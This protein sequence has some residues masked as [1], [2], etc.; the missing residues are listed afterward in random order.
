MADFLRANRCHVL[1]LVSVVI[2]SIVFIGMAQEAIAE[3]SELRVMSFNV[4]RA[5]TGFDESAAENN[6]KDA[7]FPRRDRAIRVIREYSPDLLGLQE[8]REMQIADFREALRDYAFTGVGRDDGKTAG[9]YSAIFYRKGRFTQKDSGSFWLSETPEKPGTSFY[10][11]LMAPA[12]IASWVRLSDKE[13]GREFIFLNMHWDNASE[14]AREKSAALVRERLGKLASDLPAIVTGDLN[15]REDSG[16]AVD[17]VGQ[18]GASARRLADSFREVHPKRSPNEASFNDWKGTRKGSRIDFI[19]HT[20]EF[21][22]ESADI[23]R[24]SYDGHWP[25]DHYPVTATLRIDSKR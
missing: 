5:R 7:K 25:S 23:V 18:N 11:A 15:A 9:E 24:T 3:S 19:L 10:H 20:S 2:G 13:S 12:R 1:S 17:L 6:W 4:R 8:A 16:A 21:T 22:A 14:P